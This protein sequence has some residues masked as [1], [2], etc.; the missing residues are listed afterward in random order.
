MKKRGPKGPNFGSRSIVLNNAE[1]TVR[2]QGLTANAAVRVAIDSFL[3]FADVQ[4]LD[5]ATR[6]S[7]DHRELVRASS[8]NSPSYIA[9]QAAAAGRGALDPATDII[10]LFDEAAD[11]GDPDFETD[12]SDGL[13]T[14]S[15]HTRDTVVQQLSSKLR[16][17]LRDKPL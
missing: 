15:L 12:P 17:R 3:D 7:F 9:R 8:L 6:P 14:P 1:H 13:D 16:K 2:T 4:P 5:G 10:L 11:F